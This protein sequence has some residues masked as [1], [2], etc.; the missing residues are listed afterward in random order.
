MF[1]RLLKPQIIKRFCHTH[2]KT[3]IKENKK[4]NAELIIN[5]LSEINSMLLRIEDETKVTHFFLF[6]IGLIIT[7]KK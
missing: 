7:F 6:W 2:S 4:T 3:V 1:K 5:E